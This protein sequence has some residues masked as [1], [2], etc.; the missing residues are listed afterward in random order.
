M[1]DVNSTD[2]YPSPKPS[3]IELEILNKFKEMETELNQGMVHAGVIRGYQ[4][5]TSLS[6]SRF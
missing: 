6:Q 2:E 1:F 5:Q 4:T 3:P